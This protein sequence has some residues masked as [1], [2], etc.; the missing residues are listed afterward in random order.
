V[1]PGNH[2]HLAHQLAMNQV[3][4]RTLQQHG[5]TTESELQ[6]D[7]FYLAPGEHEATVLVAF[8]QSETDY[9]V[10]LASRARGLL[11]KKRWSVEGTTRPTKASQ[12]MLDQ[13][14]TWMVGA[15][16]EHGCTFDGWGA[17]V[18]GDAAAASG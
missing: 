2:E 8:L 17:A 9:D 7:F 13:W 12:D 10:R 16:F 1:S 14:V 15:G 5:V 6:L 11:K 3:S 18:P 4:W